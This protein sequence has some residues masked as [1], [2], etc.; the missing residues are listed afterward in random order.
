MPGYFYNL[1]MALSRLGNALI[2]GHPDHSL[3]RRIGQSILAGGFWSHVPMPA[4]L[5]AHFTWAALDD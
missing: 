2:G 5:R 3:S 4:G 1:G